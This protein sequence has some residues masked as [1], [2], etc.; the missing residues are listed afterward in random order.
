MGAGWVRLHLI[1]VFLTDPIE[2]HCVNGDHPLVGNS[3]NSRQRF[4]FFG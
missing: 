3:S 4:D 2:L 1:R